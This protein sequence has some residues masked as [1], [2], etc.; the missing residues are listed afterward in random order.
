M[1]KFIALLL[2]AA[3]AMSLLCVSAFADDS[4]YTITAP[5]NGHTY[6]V[7]QI[8]TG[9]LSA[10]VLSNVKWGTNGTGTTG[11]A[12]DSN[13]LD[14]LEAA[15]GTDTEILAEV[16]KYVS[17]SNPAYTV[18]SGASVTVPAGYYL[19]KD[20]DGALADEE[21]EAYTKYIVK[22]VGNVTISPKSDVP[23]VE[24]KV[25]DTNDTT[26]TTTDW[27]DSADYDIGD[28]I[29]YQITATLGDISEYE[30]YWVKFTDTMSSGL[31]YN[32]DAKVTLDG[33]DVTSSFTISCTNNVLTAECSDVKDLGAA[34]DS[35]IVVTYTCTLNEN[36]VIG[37]QGNPNTVYLEY[38]NNPNKDHDG[39]HGKTPEDTN[40]VFT[41][42][43]VANKVDETNE[44]L[45]GAAFELFK[46]N[47]EGT[48]VSL[49]E[50]S[51]DDTT[52]FAW[53]GID[54]GDY[55]IV[56]TKTPAGY[57]S[58]DPIEFTVTATHDVLSDNPQLTELLGG[59]IFKGQVSTG[60][61][62]ADIVNES[63]STL[64]TTGGMGT[65]LFYVLGA[66]LALGAGVLLITRKRMANN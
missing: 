25:K 26:G 58:I 17:L 20:V 47:A 32:N 54:D 51:G 36:A 1:K 4:T 62:S 39:E 5:S 53:T 6:E 3:M 52:S 34:E 56:E 42:K 40:I 45:K 41:Y 38:S 55:K 44:P 15:E 60:T 16:E 59:D 31:T 33:K 19:I 7:Y 21:S 64:P 22:V 13:T 14:A 49:G 50:V 9:D 30:T 28:S 12:V 11:A 63:G 65:T 43:V 37:S 57:N 23:E 66:I 10:G 61:L 29:P 35:K 18:A 46:K 24:K 2:V 27:Q 48:Y 8:F